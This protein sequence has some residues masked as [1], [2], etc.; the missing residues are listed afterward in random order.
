MIKTPWCKRN[1]CEEQV[2]MKS[3]EESEKMETEESLSGSAKTLCMPLNQ[4]KL[5]EGTKCFNCEE[6]ALSWVMWGRSY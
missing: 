4:D 1:E 2:K 5:E 3:K 6:K